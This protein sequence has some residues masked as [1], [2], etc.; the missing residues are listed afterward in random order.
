MNVKLN[1]K[2]SQHRK[3]LEKLWFVYGNNGPKHTHGNH[4]FIQCLLEHNSD[5][6]KFFRRQGRIKIWAPLTKECETAVDAVLNQN[7]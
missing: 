6:R 4:K 1:D 2:I 5:D 7:E 3:E